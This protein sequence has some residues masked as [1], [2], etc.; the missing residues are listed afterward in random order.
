MIQEVNGIPSDLHRPSV[1]IKDT[2]KP[3]LTLKGNNPVDP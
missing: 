1:E 3:V 2:T